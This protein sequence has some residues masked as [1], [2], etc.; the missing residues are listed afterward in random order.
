MLTYPS[1]HDDVFQQTLTQW[2]ETEGEVF[3]Y[4]HHPHTG[5]SGEYYFLRSPVH[6]HALIAALAPKSILT[7]YRQRQFPLRITVSPE[8]IPTIL[9]AI[10]EGAWYSFVELAPYSEPICMHGGKDSHQELLE[11]IQDLMGGHYGIGMDPL[12]H[13]DPWQ[14]AD[15]DD[16]LIAQCPA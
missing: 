4:I 1:I 12:D 5:S 15:R 7:A 13:E 6:A 3:V 8:Q 16:I 10:P 2:I 11:D 14:Q 9:A